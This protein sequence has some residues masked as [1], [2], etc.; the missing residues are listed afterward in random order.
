MTS[1]EFKAM[2]KDLGL[3]QEQLADLIGYSRQQVINWE[4]GKYDVPRV[5]TLCMT[6]LTISGEKTLAK[7]MKTAGYQ[8]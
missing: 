6:L 8:L 4:K 2:R 3:S 1:L 7:I 5:V